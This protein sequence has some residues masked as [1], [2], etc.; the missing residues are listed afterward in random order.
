MVRYWTVGGLRTP[1]LRTRQLVAYG[2]GRCE[3]RPPAMC[4]HATGWVRRPGGEAEMPV[5]RFPGLVVRWGAL[6]SVE[7]YIRDLELEVGRD[8]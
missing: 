5:G 8:L 7:I 3:S 4:R 2:L 6:T 1:W